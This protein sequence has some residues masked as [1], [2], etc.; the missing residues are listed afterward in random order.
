MELLNSQKTGVQLSYVITVVANQHILVWSS[1]WETTLYIITWQQ[2]KFEGHDIDEFSLYFYIQFQLLLIWSRQRHQSN[3]LHDTLWLSSKSAIYE[4]CFE[5]RCLRMHTTNPTSCLIRR[6][7]KNGF[8]KP[9]YPFNFRMLYEELC[10]I[11]L[12]RVS[13]C[14]GRA[15]TFQS[16]K[17][18]LSIRY[19][20]LGIKFRLGAN[21]F[22]YKNHGILCREKMDP[23]EFR[24]QDWPTWY[25]FNLHG[26]S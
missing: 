21:Q 18:L 8:L 7:L 15:F 17:L 16:P 6:H 25:Q 1:K 24:N 14:I 12:C 26:F 22:F 11:S 10:I 20:S 2:P 23:M 9:E 3:K 5:Q 4:Q 19:R 13:L